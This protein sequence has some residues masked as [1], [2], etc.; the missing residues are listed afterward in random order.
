[1]PSCSTRSGLTRSPAVST[2]RKGNPSNTA[3]ASIASRVVPGISVT[4][5]R[6]WPSSALN[7][8]D[9]PGPLHLLRGDRPFVFF[10]EIDVV[11]D[12][13]FELQDFLAQRF[14]PARQAALELLQSTAPLRRRA[15]VDQV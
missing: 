11:R 9:V 5:A 15:G 4:M 8:D 10:G 7:S 3:G 12:Q 1:M 13:R 6:S 2:S 14:E